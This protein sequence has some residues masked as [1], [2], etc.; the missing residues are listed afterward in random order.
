[1]T[2]K[3]IR[4]A[5]TVFV[6]FFII[7]ASKFILLVPSK[8][9]IS[10]KI[11]HTG[12]KCDFTDEHAKFENAFFIWIDKDNYKLIGLDDNDIIVLNNNSYKLENNY[13]L[14]LKLFWGNRT[15]IIDTNSLKFGNYKKGK[16]TM[17][18]S[19]DE[20]TNSL[21]NCKNNSCDHN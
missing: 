21:L 14:N 13:L 3:K 5:I 4:F 2:S 16:C 10:N 6:S 8:A 15:L 12:F 11:S 19:Y 18:T 1:M 17:Y 20:L 9:E 7:A